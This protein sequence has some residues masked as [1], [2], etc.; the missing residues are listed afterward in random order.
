MAGAFQDAEGKAGD[1][2]IEFKCSQC[3]EDMEA[4]QSL[5]GQTE[6][7]PRCGALRRVPES[8]DV[9]TAIDSPQAVV[10]SPTSV[11]QTKACPYCGETIKS[12]AILCR[13][14]GMNLQTGTF[15][16]SESP[17]PQ[18][19]SAPSRV[20][21]SPARA[22]FQGTLPLMVRLAVQA[23]HQAGF[24][25]ENASEGAGIVTFR[26]GMT[27]GSWSGVAGSLVIEESDDHWFRVSGSA[28]QNLQGGQVLALDL[29]GEANSK[30]TR[31]ISM[32]KTLAKPAG[33]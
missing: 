15:S 19:T 24:R 11:P 26:T 9:A 8:L 20:Q 33:K 7:C 28:K 1:D 32:M 30:A 2:M 4:P 3:G 18:G 5:A 22:A 12:V 31:V 21:Y 17:Q 23:V 25:V 6:S 16:R 29:F 13:F 10:E 27:W 14:C